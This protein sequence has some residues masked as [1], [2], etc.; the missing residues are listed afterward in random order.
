MTS[1]ILHILDTN[2]PFFFL[3]KTVSETSKSKPVPR[4][5]DQL[6]DRAR[7]AARSHVLESNSLTPG[8]TGILSSGA[9][10]N[11]LKCFF[12]DGQRNI[13]DDVER[14]ATARGTSLIE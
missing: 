12:T 8:G 3:K 2:N 10:Y 13:N 6:M 11:D 9:G 1:G 4:L 14:P 7:V 5:K